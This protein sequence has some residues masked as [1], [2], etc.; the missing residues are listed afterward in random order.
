M[1]KNK[2][3]HL[4]YTLLCQFI[5]CALLF[6]SLFGVKTLN[7]ST[8]LTLKKQYFDKL[9]DNFQ[10]IDDTE[11]VVVT[12]TGEKNE[13]TEKNVTFQETNTKQTENE[14]KE[15]FKEDTG[16]SA[17]VSGK[18][19]KDYSVKSKDDIPAN[20]SVN[21]YT[22]NQKM[23][24]PVNGR[25]SSSFGVRKHPITG[26]L[27]F[28]AGVDVAAPTGTPIYSSFDGKVIVASYN[29]WNGNYLKIQHE[30]GIMTV[31]C[32]CKKLKVKKGDTVKAGDVIAT[33]GSTGSSTGP[34]LHFE[35]RIDNKSYDP[36]IAFKTAINAI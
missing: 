9:E 17:T 1:N 28:H 2:R 5:V 30:N 36:E 21:S 35:L 10:F 24:M 19:G 34:H 14:E 15:E 18:G 25:I 4:V 29:K 7:N 23:I 20:V 8:Y 6:G 26:K 3:D 31:Y 11:E 27:R 22:L 16:L 12:S 13:K 32:H 33:V